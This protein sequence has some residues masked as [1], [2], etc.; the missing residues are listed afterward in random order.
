MSARRDP[1]GRRQA[2]VE[3]AA[4]LIVESASTDLTHR[5]VAERAQVPLGATTYYFATL[6]DLTTAALHHLAE[7]AD[8]ALREMEGYLAAGG[9]APAAV[10]RSLSDYLADPR[11]VQADSALYF[12]GAQHSELRP[13]ALRWFDGMTRILSAH[14]DPEAARAVAVYADGAMMH[15]LVHDEPLDM[16]AI[17]RAVT[18]LMGAAPAASTTPGRDR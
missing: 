18:A 9:G 3:A 17:T 14:T 16:A 8:E 10:A 5:R 2:I 11:R 4:D 7:L 15:A 1:S 6:A 13:L 12:A